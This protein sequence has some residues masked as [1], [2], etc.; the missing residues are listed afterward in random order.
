MKTELR[1]IPSFPEYSAST[2]GR[3]W[4][5]RRHGRWLKPYRNSQGYLRVSLRRDGKTFT[6][7]IHTL[8]AEAFHGPRP[9]GMDVCHNDGN[10]SNNSATNLRYDTHSGN[11]LDMARHGTGNA[12]KTHCPQGHP[13]SE[14]NTYRSKKNRMCKTCI[15]QRNL[16][17]PRKWAK[18]PYDW[19]QFHLS[20]IPQGSTDL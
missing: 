17:R 19:S 4:S 16:L 9:D 5:S 3:I 18:D 10:P 8:V 15:R 20:V 13:Y 12:S 7:Q 1:A 6:R 11:L 2:E 14:T